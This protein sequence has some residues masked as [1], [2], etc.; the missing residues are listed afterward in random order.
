MTFRF[1]YSDFR[2][3]VFSQPDERRAFTGKDKLRHYPVANAMRHFIRNKFGKPAPLCTYHTASS[4]PYNTEGAYNTE[5]DSFYPDDESYM[6]LRNLD[7]K[8]G[9]IRWCEGKYSDYKTL[10]E[11]ILRYDRDQFSSKAHIDLM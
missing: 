5:G 4:D 10:K 2:E 3:F 6:A 8:M 7:F 9:D 1:T 11:D